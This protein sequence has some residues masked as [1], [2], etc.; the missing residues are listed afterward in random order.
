MTKKIKAAAA[1]MTGVA[2]WAYADDLEPLPLR[3]D[4]AH[5]G[6][7]AAKPAGYRGR[8][9]KSSALSGRYSGRTGGFAASDWS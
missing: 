9:R 7:H 1:R 5:Y 3:A 2:R 4:A 6:R 8:H